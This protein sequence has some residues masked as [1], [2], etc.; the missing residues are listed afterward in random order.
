MLVK[1]LRAGVLG[2]AAVLTCVCAVV[3]LTLPASATVLIDTTPEPSWRVDG[4]VNATVIVGDVVVVGGTFANAVSPSGATLPRANLAAFSLSS[5]EPLTTWRADTDATV[6][7]LVTDGTS[8]WVGGNFRNVAGV[9]KNRIAKVDASSGVLDPLFVASTTNTVRALALRGSALYLGGNFGAVNGATRLRIGKVG[10][11][12]GR[13]DTSFVAVLDGTVH[14]LAASP[15]SDEVY[16]SGAFTLVNGMPR[17][18]V[19]ALNGSTGAT[20]ATVFGSATTTVGLDI[21]PDGALLYGAVAASGN[22][23]MA[24][25]TI[26]GAR[27]WRARAD[28]DVQVVRYFNGTVYFGFHD[29]FAADTTVKLLAADARTGAL[30]PD[31]RPVIGSFWGVF[32]IAAT[33]DGVVIGGD[34]TA[35]SGQP[36]QGFAI[37]AADLPVPIAFLDASTAWRFADQGVRWA[38]WESAGFDDSS[39]PSGLPQ[40]GYGDGDETTLLTAGPDAT[41]HLAAY[42]RTSFQVTEAPNSLTLDLAA[43]DGAVVYLNGVEIVRDNMPA[44]TITNTTRSVV[45]RSGADENLLRSFTLDPALLNLGTNVI[46]VEVHQSS[47]SGAVDLTFDARLGGLAN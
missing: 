47:N 29:G 40:L 1:P 4:V 18:G 44:G 20:D 9:T 27:V 24:W 36:R 30:D 6:R 31:F 16:T 2:I 11:D 17:S 8:V 34:F 38:D 37:F 35:V 25:N 7:A 22:A 26:S 3:G 46:A 21:S 39:W 19:A 45:S 14:G 23:A 42:F 13:L 33:V 12:R 28:G 43:D 5:G 10:S 32:A 41:R 15:T